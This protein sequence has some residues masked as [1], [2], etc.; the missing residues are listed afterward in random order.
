VLNLKK[1]N[2]MKTS[3]YF[4]KQSI[5]KLIIFLNFTNLNAH[6]QKT[7]SKLIQANVFIHGAQLFHSANVVI[8]KG[9]SEIHLE[10][11][12]PFIKAQSLQ[13]GGK[14]DFIISD[15]SHFIYYPEPNNSL[16]SNA[17][18]PHLKKEIKL[19]EDSLVNLQF[20]FDMLNDRKNLLQVE[21]NIINNNK[22]YKGEGKSD[23]LALFTNAMEFYHKKMSEINAELLKIKKEEHRMSALKT[24]QE[25]RLDG[26][27]NYSLNHT[28]INPKASEPIHKI[29]M[30]IIAEN[31]TNGIINVN[32]FIDNAGWTPQYDIRATNTDSPIKLNYK[33]QIYQSSGLDW[34]EVKLVLSTSNPQKPNRKPELNPWYLNFYTQNYSYNMPKSQRE[35]AAQ[36]ELRKR[37]SVSDELDAASL[38]DYTILSETFVN[39][40]YEIKVPFKILADGKNHSVTILS[41]EV[42]TNYEY[43]AV[44][45]LDSDA[46]VMA[47]I[48]GWE[49]LN[50]ISG[51]ANIY[52]ENMYVGETY[53]NSNITSDTLIVALGRDNSIQVNRKQVKTSER[54]RFFNQ[55]KI[56]T[57][58][59]E[60]NVK[61]TKNSNIK[62]VIED[63]IPVSKNQQ[64]KVEMQ[65]NGKSDIN[66]NTGILRWNLNIKAKDS[67]TLK[68]TFI[69]KHDKDKQISQLP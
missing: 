51:K 3:N 37:E 24:R 25:L 65:D 50:L 20:D 34:N 28:P 36:S 22:I 52:F 8:P 33:A 67:K 47:R 10:G 41:K 14:G 12:S 49:D 29:K 45:K 19:L 18:P 31:Q 53:I 13:A 1:L 27:I 32:Y 39:Y 59:Y 23:S 61:N 38:A 57:Y 9:T 11:I 55:E 60:I 43:V 17:V 68:Y 6:E 62:L 69:V 7:K 15:V 66:E 35:G 30:T 54:E 64:I 48:N 4:F 26:L 2:L 42:Q 5:T 46:F 21:K 56:L 58:A 63:Q 44:P 16:T 40:Q